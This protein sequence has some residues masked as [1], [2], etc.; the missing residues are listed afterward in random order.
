MRLTVAIV[1]CFLPS[2]Y[3]YKNSNECLYNCCNV[4]LVI[5]LGFRILGFRRLLT[6][7]QGYGNVLTSGTQ[8][9]TDGTGLV[10][11]Q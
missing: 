3:S 2:E 8:R 4:G 5:Q 6:F 1:F 7:C 9:I 10:F 11:R